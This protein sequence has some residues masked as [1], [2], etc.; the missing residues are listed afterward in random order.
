MLL[1]DAFVLR[2]RTAAGSLFEEA[3]VLGGAGDG[4]EARGVE[5]IGLA[6]AELWGR[7]CLYTARPRRVLQSRDTALVVA[8]AGLHVVRLGSDGAWRAAI[9]LLDLT[10]SSTRTEAT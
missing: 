3:A 5:A 6:L 2:D 9:S 8:D 4:S 1:E 7:D 10:A